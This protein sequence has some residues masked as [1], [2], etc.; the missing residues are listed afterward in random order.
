MIITKQGN[1]DLY[2]KGLLLNE[3]MEKY[4]FEQFAKE[5]ADTR[6]TALL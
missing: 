1:V 5:A 4:L 2:L 6:S 3:F